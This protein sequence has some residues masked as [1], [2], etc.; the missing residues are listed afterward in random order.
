M[1]DKKETTMISAV[2]FI[3]KD[4]KSVYFIGD[5]EARWYSN[6]GFPLPKRCKECRETRRNGGAKKSKNK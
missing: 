2:K 3:C 5:R 4:C 6:M 1:E